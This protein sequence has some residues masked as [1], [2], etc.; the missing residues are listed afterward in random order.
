MKGARK[1]NEGGWEQEGREMEMTFA[2]TC[3]DMTLYESAT[4]T[5]GLER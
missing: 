3:Q 2:W 5:E 1:K 4:Q